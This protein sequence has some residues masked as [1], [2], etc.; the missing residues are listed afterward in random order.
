[1]NSGLAPSLA[2]RMLRQPKTEMPRKRASCYGTLQSMLHRERNALKS[3][4][5]INRCM[6]A[7]SFLLRKIINLA[8]KL[9]RQCHCAT[10]TASQYDGLI[11]DLSNERESLRCMTHCP[12]AA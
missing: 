1:M 11:R 6:A 2:S 4:T 3:G 12:T 8:S 7:M 10:Y 5:K 9:S